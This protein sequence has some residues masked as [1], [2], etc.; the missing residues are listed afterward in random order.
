MQRPI[1]LCADRASQTHHMWARDRLPAEGI[2]RPAVLPTG[3]QD[4]PAC[5][6]T[7]HE[8]L[9]YCQNTS[10]AHVTVLEVLLHD[11]LVQCSDICRGLG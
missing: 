7:Q 1:I 9:K 8:I 2:V 4:E 11:V 6:A 3:V 10:K 5:L